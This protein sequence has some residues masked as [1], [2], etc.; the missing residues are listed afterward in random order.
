MSILTSSFHVEMLIERELTFF[1]FLFHVNAGILLQSERWKKT[2]ALLFHLPVG[3]LLQLEIYF[4]IFKFS[5]LVIIL[6]TI[7]HVISTTCH[8]LWLCPFSIKSEWDSL[9]S[10]SSSLAQ[11]MYWQVQINKFIPIDVYL[12]TLSMHDRKCRWTVPYGRNETNIAKLMRGNWEVTEKHFLLHP[13]HI[14]FRNLCLCI[15]HALQHDGNRKKLSVENN[16][17]VLT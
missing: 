15:C 1:N 11:L 17:E 2:F 12:K 14:S 9:L 3:N 4:I 5:P 6:Y 13:G 10:S 16:L 8:V 7:S